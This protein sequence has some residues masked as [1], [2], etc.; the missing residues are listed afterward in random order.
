[1]KSHLIIL[2]AS[3]RA[4]AFSALRAGFEPYTIDLFADRDLTAVCTAAKIERYPEDF[5]DALAGAPQAPWMYTGGL[6]NYPRLIDKLAEI[7]PLLG[8]CGDSL[9]RSRQNH[10]LARAVRAAG[11]K[12]PPSANCELKDSAPPGPPDEWLWKPRRSSGGLLIRRATDA[13]PAVLGY[14]QRWIPGASTSAVFVAAGGSSRLLGMSHQ[15]HGRDFGLSRRF[16]YCGSL[17]PTRLAFVGTDQIAALGQQL[18]EDFGLVGLF[19]VDF[20]SAGDGVWVLELNARYSASV[21]V[22]ER[23][24]NE[25]FVGMHVVACTHQKLPALLTTEAAT[26]AGKAVVYA[27]R[28]GVIQPAFDELVARWNLP[29]QPPGIADLP[30]IGQAIAADEPVATV[31][32]EGEWPGEVEAE[33][34]SRVAAVLQTIRS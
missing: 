24:R 5:P 16:L 19:N 7:R 32:T 20:V 13:I 29:G 14:W 26:C 27:N 2:G 12:F 23:V 30:Q 31:L 25:N 6:E 34:R 17:A 3:C 28:S 18:A 33:L 8:N 11:F 1:V 4:A 10:R 15:L 21:E 9:R 22:L